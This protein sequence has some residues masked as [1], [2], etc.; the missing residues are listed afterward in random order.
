MGNK[1]TIRVAEFEKLYYDDIKPFK[2]K[3]WEALCRYQGQQNSFSNKQTEYFKI[4]NKGI[5]FT[6]YVGVIQAGNLTIEVLPKTDKQNTAAENLSVQDLERADKDIADKKQ[7]W[8]N[9][10][11]QMLK[12]CRLLQVN[13]V[14]YASLNLKSNSLL[15]LYLELFLA[16][17]EKLLH[18]GLTKKYRKEEDN[19]LVMKGQLLYAKNIAHNIVHKERFF[20]RHTEYNRTNIFNQ[21]LYK[22]LCFIPSISKS[23]RLSDKVNRLLLDFPGMP[24]CTVTPATFERL[25]FDR[26]T[27]RYKEA[28]LISKML[29]LNYRPDITGGSENVIAIL[30][31]MNELWEEFVY[32]RLHKSAKE[33]V[34]ISRQNGKDFWYNVKDGF[35]KRVRPDIV[36]NK[37]D[38]TFIIDTKWKII[39]DNRPG[40]DDLKQMFVYNL[41]WD[42][43]QLILLYPGNQ[44]NCHGSYMHFNLSLK[45]QVDVES[46]FFNHCSLAFISVIDKNGKLIDNDPFSALLNN[47]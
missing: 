20:V 40:D 36:I 41:L 5:Q 27:E 29:L 47:F 11:L 46:K 14:D 6:N 39:A 1:N 17:T 42:A 23:P 19:K 13:H 34:T 15:E 12:E 33:G 43:D 4:L 28:L 31:D 2:Q 44:E 10:L 32:R 26:K 7:C 38:K 37:N 22:T 3:H 45:N 9:V 21:L 35:H 30:F 25:V 18:E 16:E 8:H 24:D